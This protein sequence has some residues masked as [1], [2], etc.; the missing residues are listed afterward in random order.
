M[1]ALGLL[2]TILPL[3]AFSQEKTETKELTGHLG[4]RK[5][6]LMLY[7]MQRADGGWHMTGEYI[8][9]PTLARRYRF[10]DVDGRTIAPFALP[11]ELMLSDSSDP[12]A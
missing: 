4:G 7:S 1:K 8:V 6:L 10:A 3:I 11:D 12:D 9:L 5:A 2:L